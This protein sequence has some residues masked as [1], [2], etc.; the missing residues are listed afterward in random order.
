MGLYDDDKEAVTSG[1]VLDVIYWQ[2]KFAAL[3][4]EAALKSRQPEFAIKGII[5]AVVNGCMDVLKTYPNHADIKKWMD[6]AKDIEKKIDPNAPSAEF[7]SSFA[8]WKA[9]A[10]EAGWRFY[11]LAKMAAA[12]EDWTWAYSHAADAEKQLARALERMADWP[13]ETQEWIKSAYAEVQ[14][15][16]EVAAK[17]K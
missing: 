7:K 10:Y 6:N 14:R 4:L 2:T 1:D 3:K 9:F 13:T 17:K 15:L 5:P 8:Q 11:H 16:E 12:A